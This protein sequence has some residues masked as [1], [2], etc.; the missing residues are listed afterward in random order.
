MG[1]LRRLYT[2]LKKRRIAK[3]A[4]AK[5][6]EQVR[7]LTRRNGGWSMEQVVAS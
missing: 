6:K 5:M 4:L 7:D 1:L 3:K 2:R